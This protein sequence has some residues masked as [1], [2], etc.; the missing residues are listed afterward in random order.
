MEFTQLHVQAWL[1]LG[2]FLFHGFFMFRGV[3]FLFKTL[4]L[5]VMMD[6]PAASIEMP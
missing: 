1:Q 5:W 3:V 4:A 6:M 2:V